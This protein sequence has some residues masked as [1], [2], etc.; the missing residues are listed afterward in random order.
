MSR[1]SFAPLAGLAAAL[2]CCGA[3]LLIGGAIA[4]WRAVTL[5]VGAGVLAL[6]GVLGTVLSG[7][8]RP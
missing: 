7:R 5:C 6:G 1:E 4:G 3:V 2:V 8:E